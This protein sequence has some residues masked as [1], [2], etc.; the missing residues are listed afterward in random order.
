MSRYCPECDSEN[1][2]ETT[3]S[4]YFNIERDSPIEILVS[5]LLGIICLDCG[6]VHL[7]PPRIRHNEKIIEK[8]IPDY[9]L[10]FKKG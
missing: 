2:S 7:D 8:A 3:Y 9:F 4:D 5:G 10:K 6:S 1:L